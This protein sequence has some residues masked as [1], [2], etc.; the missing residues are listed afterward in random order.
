MKEFI[1]SQGGLIAT[2][3]AV[4]VALNF[5]LSGVIKALEMFKDKTESKAD[6]NLW[7]FLRKCAD[8]V[9]KVIEWGTGNRPHA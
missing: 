3:V 9:T 8:V 1:A 5:V 2:I 6:D 4:A 7:A